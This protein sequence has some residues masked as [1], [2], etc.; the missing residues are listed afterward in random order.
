[1]S[2]PA[3]GRAGKD[4]AESARDGGGANAFRPSDL[5][6]IA[7][8]AAAI[9][10]PHAGALAGGPA[11][12]PGTGI[13]PLPAAGFWLAMHAAG[14]IAARRR[15]ICRRRRLMVPAAAALLAA[16][17]ASLAPAGA[18]SRG[19][20]GAHVASACLALSI[21]LTSAAGIWLLYALGRGEAARLL[22][23]VSHAASSRTPDRRPALIGLALALGLAALVPRLWGIDWGLP[24]EYHSDEHLLYRNGLRPDFHP[25]TFVYPALMIYVNKAL[26]WTIAA[27]HAAEN[28]AIAFSAALASETVRIGTQHA[29]RIAVALLS[30]LLPGMAFPL[31]HRLGAPLWLAILGALLLAFSPGLVRH[32]HYDTVDVPCAVLASVS[33]LLMLLAAERRTPRVLLTA[34]L[35]A[36]LAAGTKYSA[37]LLLLP[38]ATSVFL[39][40]PR[41]GGPGTE[42]RALQ[43]SAPFLAVCAGLMALG[44]TLVNPYA[45]IEWPRA[46][47]GILHQSVHSRAGHLGAE[48]SLV[49][50]VTGPLAHELGSMGL[51]LPCF[52]GLIAVRQNPPGLLIAWLAW[53]LPFAVLHL[54]YPVRFSRWFIPV[55][56]AHVLL[57]VLAAIPRG[58]LRTV[59]V[60]ASL[61]ILGESAVASWHIARDFAAPD[62]RT[63]ARG[64]LIENAP[65]NASLAL[66]AFDDPDRFEGGP[67]DLLKAGFRLEAIPI[68]TRAG[69]IPAEWD[70]AHYAA[71]PVDY[72]LW[73]DQAFGR[74]ADPRIA[75]DHPEVHA[76]YARFAHWLSGM[77]LAY[78]SPSRP[79]HFGPEIRIYRLR[80]R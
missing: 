18:A 68:L 14:E 65:P 5:A 80:A 43:A 75:E 41:A 37:A 20:L 13:A 42:G 34:S 57:P 29:A 12:R 38:I 78:S 27:L 32:S 10:L 25:G 31:L 73:S 59:P 47:A 30:A 51:L 44:F 56:P 21:V 58:W 9:V 4:A 26:G 74:Y 71:H 48:P 54:S 15:R 35:V 52:A 72:V 24:Y 2:E 53:V 66:P 70:P 23:A 17:V 46:L 49:E 69:R 60:L 55:V 22:P 76:A 63:A 62:T 3:G 16:L 33:I 8:A 64:W 79:S 40:A 7:I 45:V 19:G 39:L 67:Q 77:E 6:L 50:F 28:D 36:G 11:H 61:L 1:M